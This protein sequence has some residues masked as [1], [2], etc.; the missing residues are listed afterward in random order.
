MKLNTQRLRYDAILLLVAV[1]WGS[2]FAVQRV[3]AQHLGSFLFNGLRFLLAGMLLLPFAR[4]PQ[5]LN[6]HNLPWVITAGAILFISSVL[7]QL[8]LATTTAGNAG[9][10][11]SL[12]VVLVPVLLLL[13][14]RRH[15]HGLSWAAAGVA[16]VGAWLLSTGGKSLHLA[17][18]DA[19][20]LLGALGWAFHVI[21]ISKGAQKTEALAFSVGQC[22]VA[23][24][25]NLAM[26]FTLERQTLPGLA[27]A[28]WC[29]VYV[30]VFSTAIGYTLQIV[31]QRHSPPTDASLILSL[32]SVFAAL[33]GFLLLSERLGLVQFLGCALILGA[34]VL[35]QFKG[36][37]G[38]N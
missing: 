19:Y 17:A 16:A 2:A 31:G 7:Q 4:L 14:W 25:L 21:V 35:A 10:I 37:P 8:G 28:W 12:Y 6:R 9:F 18:G 13:L 3:A 34:V 30:G 5:R 23:A 36:A 20:E 27:A 22:C 11:T 33:F 38:Y 32:E 15:S 1:I 26:G 29:V 24:A